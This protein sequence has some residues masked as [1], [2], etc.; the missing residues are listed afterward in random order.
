MDQKT[1]ARGGFRKR[2]LIIG[3][4]LF[5][6]LIAYILVLP[7]SGELELQVF[8][9]ETERPLPNAR[10]SWVVPGG[11]TNDLK[12]ITTDSSG[13]AMIP[14]SEFYNESTPAFIKTSGTEPGSTTTNAFLQRYYYTNRR[15]HSTACS[16]P[17]FHEN[18]GENSH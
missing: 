16:V 6:A 14:V 7:P 9:F 17:L 12:V 3:A 10:V 8:D 18:A 1:S 15:A 11:T 2:H 5:I 4:F 13:V